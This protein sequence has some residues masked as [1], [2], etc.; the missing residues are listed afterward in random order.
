MG[1][2]D[3][4]IQDD[5]VS[6]C[7]AELIQTSEGGYTVN[8]LNSSNGTFLNGIR[9]SSPARVKAG[10]LLKVG[11]LQIA[12]EEHVERAPVPKKDSNSEEDPLKIVSLDE[13]FPFEE[14]EYINKYLIAS[15]ETF[16]VAGNTGGILK[17]AAWTEE[18]VSE[19]DK[20]QGD[21]QDENAEALEQAKAEMRKELAER[22]HED[23]KSRIQILTS[24]LDKALKEISQ[25]K[26]INEQQGPN[27]E[28]NDDHDAELEKLKQ[29]ILESREDN[30]TLRSEIID[31]EDRLAVSERN[32][33]EGAAQLEQEADRNYKR[34]EAL[35][36]EIIELEGRLAESERK[37]LEKTQDKARVESEDHA[38]ELE[39][40]KQETAQSHE[41]NSVLRS[42]ISELKDK[43]AESERKLLEDARVES[44]TIS[45][46]QKQITE[47]A[48]ASE[49]F[50]KAT[51]TLKQSNLDLQQQ[52][53]TAQV[54]S[55]ESEERESQLRQNNAELVEKLKI[56]EGNSAKLEVQIETATSSISKNEQLIDKLREQLKESEASSKAGRKLEAKLDSAER[57]RLNAEAK[58]SRLQE[59]LASI[60]TE[61]RAVKEQLNTSEKT[62]SELEEELARTIEIRDE[63]ESARNDLKIQLNQSDHTIADLKKSSEELEFKLKKADEEK[64]QIHADLQSTREGLSAALHATHQ[65]L[66][67]ASKDLNVEIYLRESV[68]KQLREAAAALESNHNA[69]QAVALSSGDTNLNRI[70]DLTEEKSEEMLAFEARLAALY[71]SDDETNAKEKKPAENGS[72]PKEEFYRQFIDKLDLVDSFA[73]LYEN[74]WR[75]SKVAQQFAQL[76]HA[77]LELLEEYSVSQFDLEPGT[78][79]GMRQKHRFDLAPNEDGTIPK[80]DPFGNSQVA[81]TVCPGFL[82]HDDSREIIIRKAKVAVR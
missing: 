47:T 13:E 49:D 53:D 65:R 11:N 73:S 82:L 59:K 14:E 3:L 19:S 46:L 39:K 57:K 78:P 66:A 28:K 68:E 32:Q 36:A 76:K 38:A 74:K 67:D 2:N 60:K 8:D 55:Q 50:E 52:L 42:E 80:I 20:G 79:L 62:C 4:R 16:P 81:A 21:E 45:Q 56:A 31:L 71:P 40:L 61:T 18:S 10:D 54:A 51:E 12:V 23:F 34:N 69:A 77:F 75:Y 9:I 5:S 70:S 30:S 41:E 58:V 24:E 48:S 1:D 27:P 7:H 17:E 44:D 43:L 26:G 63:I 15:G 37:L 64:A 29:E 25:L 33:A 35:Q 72:F 6:R 22:I